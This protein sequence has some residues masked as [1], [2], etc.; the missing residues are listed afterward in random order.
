MY[1]G[2]RPF[3]PAGSIREVLAYAAANG[4]PSGEAMAAALRRV[5]LERLVDQLDRSGRWDRDL[6]LGE[7]ER[8]GYARLVL[9]RPKWLI[10]DQALD[11]VDEASRRVILSILERELADTAVLNIAG[12][13]MPEG[14]YGR[15]LHLVSEPAGPGRQAA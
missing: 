13:P 5:G 9:G 15:T 1:L 7:Q 10:C 14:F 3:V 6:T 8:L 11:P 12:T 2:A 4:E